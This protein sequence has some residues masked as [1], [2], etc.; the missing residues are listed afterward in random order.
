MI[1]AGDGVELHVVDVNISLGDNEEPPL[2]LD[3][4]EFISY[5]RGIYHEVKQTPSLV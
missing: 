2:F 3:I 1:L 5:N 4:D